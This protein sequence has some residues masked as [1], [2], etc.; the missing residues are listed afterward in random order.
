MPDP[1]QHN[2]PNHIKAR[3][4][5]F[6]ARQRLL[7]VFHSR[8]YKREVHRRRRV[9]LVS[10]HAHELH[11]IVEPQHCCDTAVYV[12]GADVED[13]GHVAV[14]AAFCGAFIA[15]GVDAA[16]GYLDQV[17]AVHD[18]LVETL[19]YVAVTAGDWGADPI[20]GYVGLW[21]HPRG[22]AAGLAK[23][24]GVWDRRAGG[25]ASDVG[26]MADV[27]DGGFLASTEK[28]L[29]ADEFVGA[30][31]AGGQGRGRQVRV[32]NK[33]RV[34]GSD[35]AVEDA[36]D[37]AFALV[38]LLPEAVVLV[39]AEDG[40]CV[41]GVQVEGFVDVGV[42]EAGDG[43]HEP[44][45]VWSEAGGE[46]GHGGGIRVDHAGFAGVEGGVGEERMVPAFTVDVGE[47]FSEAIRVPDV[48]DVDLGLVRGDY[49]EQGK[50]QGRLC[51]V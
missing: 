2:F 11:A 19:D 15:G 36:D 3:H 38:G 46:A 21:S 1:A 4:R 26:P 9:R 35:A 37:N 14:D 48:D 7:G 12:S 22:G 44:D 8:I 47:E 40:R 30:G 24:A 13:P 23:D 39:E 51:L 43:L 32:G 10:R 31:E 34:V 17:D 18:G 6:L 27:V 16:N 5:S 50:R 28:D 45:F 41:G 20:G 33:G 49:G 29:G 25:D 42:K